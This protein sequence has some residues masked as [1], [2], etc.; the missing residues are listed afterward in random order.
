MS[1]IDLIQGL[2]KKSG[3]KKQEYSVKT[4]DLA[5][6]ADEVIQKHLGTVEGERDRLYDELQ[7]LKEK[8]KGTKEKERIKELE[9]VAQIEH[10]IKQQKKRNK[11]SIYF[12]TTPCQ[13]VSGYDNNEFFKN[14]ENRDMKF[15]KG[16]SFEL[17]S[18][19]D[20]RM[21]LILA[22]GEKLGE[23]PVGTVEALPYLFNW[24]SFINDMKFG[25]IPINM[26][27]DGVLLPQQMTLPEPKEDVKMDDKMG[28]MLKIDLKRLKNVDKDIR[29]AFIS[30]YRLLNY[31]QA[32]A[33]DSEERQRDMLSQMRE[34]ETT[35]DMLMKDQEQS[36]NQL[37][38]ALDTV[39]EKDRVI[40]PLKTSEMEAQLK[41]AN[42]ETLARTQTDSLNRIQERI[43][44]LGENPRELARLEFKEDYKYMVERIKAGE[45]AVKNE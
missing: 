11:K 42:A 37:A 44:E 20:T 43:K 13:I 32:R 45:K 36:R 35:N 1:I 6:L 18:S 5:E 21:N 8:I 27:V 15:W 23:L 24:D 19:G 16:M 33:E 17:T 31:A 34:L 2:K 39:M 40:A 7:T 26:T 25:R 30:L 10:Q 14:G 38:I 9:K 3:I 29:S 41:A 28:K 4:E 12:K 22:D